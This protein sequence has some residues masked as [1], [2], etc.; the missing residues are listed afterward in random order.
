MISTGKKNLI[1]D[2]DGVLVGNSHNEQVCT[3]CTVITP[4]EGSL[5]Q[6]MLEVVHLEQGR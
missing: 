6:Q 4:I 2:V 1:T 3:G 5:L